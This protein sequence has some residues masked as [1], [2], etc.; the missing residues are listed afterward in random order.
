MRNK[1][2]YGENPSIFQRFVL[3]TD[4]KQILID[5]VVKK[6]RNNYSKRNIEFLDIGCAD[7]A[8]TIPIVEELSKSNNINV[9]GIEYSN[10]LL[11]DFKNNTNIKVNLINK[12]VELLDELPLSNFILI[13][14]ILPYINDLDSFL[15]K[16]IKALPKN[17][18]ALIVVSNPFSDDAKIKNQILDRKDKEPLSSKIQK[19]LN[20]KKITFEKEVIESTIDVSGLIN[21]SEDGKTLIE[22]FNH[23]SFDEILD[24]DVKSMRELIL[25]CAN[26]E[27]HLTKKEDYF[28]ISNKK[29]HC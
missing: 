27:G 4:Q 28:W 11:N 18:I 2:M 19:L 12:N 16:V 10:A 13:S 26:K 20:E 25:S 5:K 23:K 21:M 3:L 9:T 7:G 1:N 15:D 6:I 17:S 14:H 24:N 29:E 8:V 22:F